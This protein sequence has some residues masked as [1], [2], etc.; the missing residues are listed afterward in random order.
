M[1]S[2]KNL[3]LRLPTLKGETWGE[4]KHPSQ[5]PNQK[6]LPRRK[7][8]AHNKTQ[9]NPQKTHT[10][11]HQN[12]THQRLFFCPFFLECDHT[13]TVYLCIW[14]GSRG[15]CPSS[16]ACVCVFVLVYLCFLEHMFAKQV[17]SSPTVAISP[18]KNKHYRHSSN[19]LLGSPNMVCC[20]GV[21]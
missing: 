13:K 14:V 1:V 15:T 12:T 18:Q 6:T 10:P 4:S 7:R 2:A 9:T 8:L 20:V 11:R 5:R 16:C 19:Y 3:G 17:F 21:C